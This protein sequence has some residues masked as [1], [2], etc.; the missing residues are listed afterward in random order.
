WNHFDLRDVETRH[1][2]LEEL[3]RESVRSF[4]RGAIIEMPYEAQARQTE[5][6]HLLR[7]GPRSRLLR[8]GVRLARFDGSGGRCRGVR[9]G[10]G[11]G[12]RLTRELPSSGLTRTL[13]ESLQP[14][15]QDTSE[16][17]RGGATDGIVDSRRGFGRRPWR[18]RSFE[19]RGVCLEF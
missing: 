17:F 12:L 10:R 13:E 15:P 4:D 6:R 7:A 16:E 19:F 1:V 5:C 2:A 8:T 9:G 11:N 14:G 3:F 18:N